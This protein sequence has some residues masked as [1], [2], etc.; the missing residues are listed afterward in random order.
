MRHQ[1]VLSATL[2]LALA[3]CATN[4]PPH[5]GGGHRFGPPGDMPRLFVSPAGQVFR[6]EPGAPTPIAAWFAQ[7]D[8]DGDGTIIYAEFQADFRRAFASFDTDHDG[9][10]G[11]DEVTSYET[12]IFPEMATRGRSGFGGGGPGMGGGGMAGGRGG[13]GGGHGGGGKGCGCK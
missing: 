1:S 3:G 5:R 8:T 6:A 7:A 4:G 2:L 10:I 13:R 12:E 9:E 11:P